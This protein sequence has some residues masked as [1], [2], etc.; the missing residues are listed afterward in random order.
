MKKKLT[1]TIDRKQ[2]IKKWILL[3]SQADRK[4]FFTFT[5]GHFG[6]LGLDED[7]IYQFFLA[8]GLNIKIKKL[9]LV[10]FEFAIFLI[11]A[12]LP[13]K[14]GIIL[15]RTVLRYAFNSKVNALNPMTVI[16]L[17]S[18]EANNDRY[19]GPLLRQ[20]DGKFDYLKIVAGYGIRTKNFIY[21]E[22]ALSFFGLVYFFLGVVF[23]PLTSFFYLLKN[24]KK[25][26]GFNLKIM[27]FTLGLRESYNGKVAQ[28]QLLHRSVNCWIIRNSNVVE[29]ILFPMEGRS[30]EKSIVCLMTKNKLESIGYIHC[31]VTPKH[32]S[33]L[34]PGFYKTNEIPKVII[35]PSQMIKQL[36]QETFAGSVI[37]KGYFLRGENHRNLKHLKLTNSKLLFALTGDARE[38][39][40]IMSC[41][42]EAGILKSHRVCVRL[43]PNTSSYLNLIK[44]AKSIGISIYTHHE[45]AKPAVCFFRSSSVALDYL[46]IN[47]PIVYLSL[48]EA[49]T[50]NVFDLDG[51]YKCEVLNVSSDFFMDFCRIVNQSESPISAPESKKISSYYL[52][53]TYNNSTLKH[54]FN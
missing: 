36:V 21:I 24:I 44:Y 19:F 53:Q 4:G 43:N 29:K 30:W 10:F 22:T 50:G 31:V 15:L 34:V 11:L 20:L 26:K 38:S 17:G 47:V 7:S 41:I 27:Y 42:L 46:N 48:G 3:F 13:I 28:N 9:I 16:S 51:T 14:N 25:I 52:D 45:E 8:K 33:L 40:K 49:V 2:D 54:F 32:F 23:L 1:E 6:A 12:I 5:S 18:Q 39:K 35:A 37:E